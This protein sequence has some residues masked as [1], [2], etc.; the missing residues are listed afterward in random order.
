MLLVNFI[1]IFYY[2]IMA[3]ATIQYIKK[4]LCISY[5]EKTLITHC[6]RSLIIISVC[7]TYVIKQKWHCLPC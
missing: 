7:I 6:A 2:L 1:T 4:K 5:I 3:K